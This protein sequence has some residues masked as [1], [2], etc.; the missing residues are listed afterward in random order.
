MTDSIET[1]K[2]DE[3]AQLTAEIDRLRL[4]NAELLD[5][6][7]R[8]KT[9]STAESEEVQALR[10]EVR[11]LRLEKPLDEML[12]ELFVISPRLARME[13]EQH[14]E[15]ELDEA[16]EIVMLDKQGQPVTVTEPAKDRYSDPISRPVGF[17]SEDLR[18]HLIQR[19]DLDTILRGSRAS[20]GGASTSRHTEYRAPEEPKPT[21]T[22]KTGF[23][24][25]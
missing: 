18:K 7:K 24:L 19:G 20:G 3:N 4:K 11:G 23:G 10:A 22:P 2:T 17:N 5:E 1:Q 13:L 21:H 16:G 15:F 14:Y 9:K 25:R 8:T 6:L 12:A